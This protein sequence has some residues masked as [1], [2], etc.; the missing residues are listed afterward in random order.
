MEYWSTGVLRR[1]GIAPAYR[2][3]DAG[4]EP[5]LPEPVCTQ[6]SETR[7][8]RRRRVLS[9]RLPKSALTPLQSTAV[10]CF[11]PAARLVTCPRRLCYF[12]DRS[13]GET[14]CGTFPG[15]ACQGNVSAVQCLFARSAQVP[16]NSQKRLPLDRSAKCT[17]RSNSLLP[18]LWVKPQ[19]E[20]VVFPEQ[21]RL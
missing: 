11:R 19:T 16:S 2:V 17:S 15:A 12:A 8:L 7:R 13:L 18:T 10:D 9:R 5:L 4:G 3:G 1:V 6:I 14:F 20:P 21:T